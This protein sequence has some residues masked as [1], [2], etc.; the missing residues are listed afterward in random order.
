[1]RYLRCLLCAILL[2]SLAA[3]T[4]VAEP[5]AN[6]DL[7]EL[8][9][10]VDQDI[11]LLAWSDLSEIDKTEWFRFLTAVAGQPVEPTDTAAEIE[12]IDRLKTAL[13]E[14]GCEHLYV[15]AS[16]PELATGNLMFV[17]PCTDPE[18]V[19]TIVG[20]LPMPLPEMEFRIDGNVLL[21]GA[22][23]RLD[24]A[25]KHPN[26]PS[27]PMSQALQHPTAAAP[28]GVVVAPPRK[29]GELLQG[30][31]KNNNAP[32]AQTFKQLAASGNDLQWALLTGKLPPQDM[33]LTVTTQD[34]QAAERLDQ[35]LQKILKQP[36]N[37]LSP[38]TTAY[39]TVG[40]QLIKRLG[41]QA[42][43]V[44]I[45]QDIRANLLHAVATD[46]QTSNNMKH[47]ALALHRYHDAYGQFPPQALTDANGRRL[48][49]WRVL[50]LPYLNQQALY[51]QFRLDEPWDSA[52]NLKLAETIPA[53][54]AANNQATLKPG[55][56]R[57]V[58]PLTKDSAFGRSGKPTRFQ[59]ITDG[60]SAT[61]WFAQ[62]PTDAAVPWSQPLDW[63]VDQAA[64]QA[65]LPKPDAAEL[66][67]FIDGSIRVLTGKVDWNTFEK[68]L[69]IDGREV[70]DDDQMP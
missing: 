22:T 29:L 15:I 8:L 57:V 43:A 6:P 67:A 64:Y 32:G 40:S 10:Y 62:G 12:A 38:Q 69:T 65:W 68:L 23:L 21:Y 37:K 35:T 33:Q 46:L 4:T 13:R 52:H 30:M 61:L 34:P 25:V 36:H 50:I 42:E 39:S 48:L 70:I 56:T 2:T 17:F 5:P 60:T 58:A 55:Y 49:S 27:K 20:G 44:A 16:L 9:P 18:N 45:L 31:L 63:K 19:K 47:V 54:Y 14:A 53:P 7:R 41:D 11:H 3:H 24:A 66:V 59:N 28:Q 51:D 26:A 1:M